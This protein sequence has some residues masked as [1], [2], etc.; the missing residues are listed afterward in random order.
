MNNTMLMMTNPNEK[1]GITHTEQF[2][3]KA[4]EIEYKKNTLTYR[5]HTAACYTF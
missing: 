5:E 1:H 2:L 3:Y 4:K